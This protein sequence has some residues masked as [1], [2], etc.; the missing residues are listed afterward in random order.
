MSQLIKL[1]I[2]DFKL[3]FRDPSL[4]IFFGLPVIFFV[5]TLWFLPNLVEQYE[6]IIPYLPLIVIFAMFENTQGFCFIN[7]M[8]F[9]DEK[10]T[11][12]A[13]VYGVVPVGKKSFVLSRLAIPYALTLLLNAL[14]L[15]L[16]PFFDLSVFTIFL[17]PA[18]FA[19]IVPVYVLIIN[20]MVKNRLEG[21]MYIKVVNIF[22]LLPFAAFFVP[23]AFKHSFGL[24]PT[25]WLYQGAENMLLQKD[26]TLFLFLSFIFFMALLWYLTNR[27][28]KVHF[29]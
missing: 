28:V 17:L 23:A 16:Q 7:T 15:Y 20:V 29:E 19:L 22:V 9:V 13:K 25:H 12:V 4:R 26:A 14:F 21:L 8:V 2:N 3:I 6:G 24:L 1:S 18:L 11:N 10:E 5:L 27:F